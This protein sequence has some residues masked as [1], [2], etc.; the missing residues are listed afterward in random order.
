[1]KELEQLILSKSRP[2]Q[3]EVKQLQ[4]S[5][6]DRLI[7]EALLGEEQKLTIKPVNMGN[8]TEGIFLLG[9]IAKAK[10]GGARI[11]GNDIMKLRAEIA[12][13]ATAMEEWSSAI[14]TEIEGIPAYATIKL[15]QPMFRALF[16][17]AT[18]DVKKIPKELES[19]QSEKNKQWQ[20]LV[21]AKDWKKLDLMYNKVMSEMK[22]RADSVAAYWNTSGAGGWKDLLQTLAATP[23]AKKITLVADGISGET[24]T[25]A[26]AWVEV[27]GKIVAEFSLKSDS[28]QI[29]Q[30]GAPGG[31]RK[32]KR[33]KQGE[34]LS[35]KGGGIATVATRLG[36]WDYVKTEAPEAVKFFEENSS[37]SREEIEN[38]PEVRKAY[39]KNWNAIMDAIQ[40][41]LQKTVGP[42]LTEQVGDQEK[43]KLSI[44]TALASMITGGAQNI[45]M[46]YVDLAKAGAKAKVAF[47][48]SFS[49]YARHFGLEAPQEAQA[50]TVEKLD[51][52]NLKQP[53]MIIT[54]KKELPDTRK[55][56]EKG[57]W[58]YKVTSALESIV[59]DT[60][61]ADAALAIFGEA[62]L[63]KIGLN[64]NELS[65]LQ[66]DEDEDK[67]AK[68]EALEKL[69]AKLREN[70]DTVYQGVKTKV[71]S[72]LPNNGE[73]VFIIRWKLRLGS[74]AP[75]SRTYVEKKE[76]LEHIA[77]YTKYLA[78]IGATTSEE[79]TAAITTILAASAD[80]LK[81]EEDAAIARMKKEKEAKKKK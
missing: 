48:K 51:K 71:N 40:A 25:T 28:A 75:E 10:K 26:D 2:V 44:L 8:V 4:K 6:L 56:F 63:K 32:V 81:A 3:K 42:V 50:G 18:N 17:P 78:S 11:S 64:A 55:D 14:G 66:S 21:Q 35:D 65:V 9:A 15:K 37:P 61:D 68:E 58:G 46:K 53:Y 57:E 22:G 67:R 76:G 73:Q 77:N 39:V 59:E 80:R 74:G 62:G 60:D 43:G 52:A 5:E 72:L 27:D 23:N 31:K 36:V 19:V 45:E 54:N 33:G 30:A 24:T 47:P 34:L 20:N 69:K 70:L 79:V 12:L 7:I 38:E 49:D 41:G 1:M 13:K 29:Y 16:L